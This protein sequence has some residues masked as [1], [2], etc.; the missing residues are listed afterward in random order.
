MTIDEWLKKEGRSGRWLAR[1]LGRGEDVV[2]RWRR[3]H[4]RPSLTVLG[5]IEEITG[6]E[7]MPEDYGYG[8]KE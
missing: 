1:K 2:S 8:E 5:L 6:G 3:G 4:I 7:V